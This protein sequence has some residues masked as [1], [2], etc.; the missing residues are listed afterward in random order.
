MNL[1][2]LSDQ[3]L[4]LNTK[5]LV[6]EESCLLTKILHHIR[7]IDRRRLFADFKQP[8]LLE[9]VMTELGY[10][11]DQALR[12]IQ[13]MRMM[14]E[15]PIVEIKLESGELNL[16]TI[17]IVQT[18]FSHEK[19]EGKPLSVA[20]KA[21]VIEKVCGKST[22]EA[23][24]I[25]LS[26]SSTPPKLNERIKMIVPDL[27]ELT[28]TIDEETNLII[29]QLRG[30]LAHSHPNISNGELIKV[31]G[32]IGLEE[33]A[34]VKSVAAP[35]LDSKAEIRRNIWQCDQ[36]KCSNC[37]STFAVQEDHRHPKAKGGA[38]TISN[39]RLLCRSCN[40][41]AAICQFGLRKM[42]KHFAPSNSALAATIPAGR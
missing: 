40:Q 22:R 37:G 20:E 10:P 19:K 27:Y 11:R 41:R 28:T 1:S 14:R 35:R 15:N 13:A 29:E 30:M 9:L 17:G 31:L 24:R 38:Y 32:K 4:M 5:T 16:T 6:R 26:L 18:L 33:L 23:Q 12:R 3:Q 36:H 2:A 42:Q 39:M 25:V 8:G 7:E 21:A 34:R